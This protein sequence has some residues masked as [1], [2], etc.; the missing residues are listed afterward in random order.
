MT[1]TNKKIYEALNDLKQN[2]IIN[3]EH[4]EAHIDVDKIINQTVA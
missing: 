1:K 3:T 4:S 2:K